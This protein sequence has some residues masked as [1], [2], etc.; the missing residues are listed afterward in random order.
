MKSV[1]TSIEVDVP[2]QTCYNQWTQFE[3]FPSFMEGVKEVTQ[4]D[5]KRLHWTAEIAGTRKM[6][7]AEITEQ[8]PDR[9]IAWRSTSGTYNAGTVTFEALGPDRTKV[10]LRLEFEPEDAAE[11]IGAI[12]QVPDAQIEADMNRFKDFIESRRVETGAW[13]GQIEGAK[14]QGE[15][16]TG[17][18]G[19]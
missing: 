4:L 9:R 3:T 6:W 5:D 11:K 12:L 13:R 15:G 14:V 2:I 10:H 19:V 16:E 7:D 17:L 8:V 18:Q 1:E